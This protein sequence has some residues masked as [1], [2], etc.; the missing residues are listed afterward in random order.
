MGQVRVCYPVRQ[1]LYE[2][3]TSV[4]L[5]FSLDPNL[6]GLISA[7]GAVPVLYV[8][9]L[10]WSERSKPAIRWFLIALGAGAVWAISNGAATFF[11]SPNAT[12]A[13]DQMMVFSITLTSVAWFLLAVEFTTRRKVSDSAFGVFLIIPLITQIL[14]V[15]EPTLIYSS[16]SVN[17]QGILLTEMGPWLR[18]DINYYAYSLTI[19]A[20]VL[21]V[22]ELLTAN[23]RRQLQSSFL[24]G[25]TLVLAISSKIYNLGF[26]P[27]YFLPTPYFLTA[28]GFGF[29]YAVSDNSATR[30]FRLNPVARDAVVEQADDLIL[31]VNWNGSISDLNTTAANTLDVDNPIGKNAADVLGL[32]SLD[33]T[34][35]E[36]KFDGRWYSYNAIEVQYGESTAGQALILRDIN[37]MKQRET[38]LDLLQQTMSRVFRH[39]I[40]NTITPIKGY[41]EMLIDHEDE[42]VASRAEKIATAADD[43]ETISSKTRD[44][45][46]IVKHREKKTVDLTN[47]LNQ[48][49]ADITEEYPD[50]PLTV[51]FDVDQD[52]ATVTAHT[53]LHRAIYEAVE[54]SL[55]HTESEEILIRVGESKDALTIEIEDD[56]PGIPDYELAPLEAEQETSHDHVSG[57]GLW[58]I[59]WIVKRSNGEVEF[60]NTDN[61]SRVRL[62]IPRDHD[63]KPDYRDD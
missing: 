4:G 37:R 43:I 61:G 56:G 51:E 12:L 44:I 62:T 55:Y 29:I 22:G 38:E 13:F 3:K 27:P 16:A 18:L 1:P 6:V 21:W 33:D 30:L 2:S 54:N 26:V 42:T 14:Y 63:V 35:Q 32:D 15:V 59:Q 53:R 46:S 49:A 40:R 60:E 23:R 28:I 45:E 34:N 48:V 17:E 36:L 19:G 57:V 52:D 47:C 20:I 9:Y 41:A 24:I 7:V 58:L 25:A 8:C 50:A 31:T 11:Y 5:M 10:L 39:N